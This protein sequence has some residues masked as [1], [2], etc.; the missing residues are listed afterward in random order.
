MLLPASSNLQVSQARGSCKTGG[1]KKERQ[2]YNT[3]SRVAYFIPVAT[4]TSGVFA[5]EAMC[6]ITDIAHHHPP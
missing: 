6:L 5:Q 1:S 2:I 3:I 4:E